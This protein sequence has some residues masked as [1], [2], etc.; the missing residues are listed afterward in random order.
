V[1]I[2]IAS[3]ETVVSTPLVVTINDTTSGLGKVSASGGGGAPGWLYLSTLA[4]LV[5]MRRFLMRAGRKDN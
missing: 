5:G 1:A 2:N 4:A 3:G